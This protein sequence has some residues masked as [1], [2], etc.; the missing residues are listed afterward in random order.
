MG[1]MQRKNLNTNISKKDMHAVVKLALSKITASS[2]IKP[3]RDVW[4]T[5]LK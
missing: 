3:V 1:E 4:R 2:A 5:T